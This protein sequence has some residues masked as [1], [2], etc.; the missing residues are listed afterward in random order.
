MPRSM[1]GFARVE[2]E[3]ATGTLA[4]EARSL[5]S[6]YLELSLKLPRAASSLEQRVR[7]LVKRHLKRGRVDVSVKW[8]RSE[9]ELRNPDGQRGCDRMV[10]RGLPGTSRMSTS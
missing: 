9:A 8:D 6:R 7:E 1:T 10:R 3:T 4:A 5:N 2:T